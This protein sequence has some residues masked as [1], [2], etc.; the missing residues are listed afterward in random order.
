MLTLRGIKPA[1]GSALPGCW[2]RLR[3]LRRRLTAEREVPQCLLCCLDAILGHEPLPLNS[4]RNEEEPSTLYSCLIDWIV[5]H[6][7]EKREDLVR[8]LRASPC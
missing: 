7:Q 1:H 4:T 2:G 6:R 8:D 5:V 3:L